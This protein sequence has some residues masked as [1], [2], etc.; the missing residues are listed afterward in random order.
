MRN[1]NRFWWK[2]FQKK[3]DCSNFFFGYCLKS[4]EFRGP[5]EIKVKEMCTGVCENFENKNKKL[6]GK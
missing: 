3:E 4:L 1:T 6:G 2:L 5:G